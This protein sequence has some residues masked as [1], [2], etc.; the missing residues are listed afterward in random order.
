MSCGNRGPDRVDD[1]SAAMRRG[2]LAGVAGES[3]R[4]QGFRAVGV[5][6][7]KL[8]APVVAKRGGGVLV[9]LKADWAAV[10]GADW[11]RTAWPMS[12][13]RDGA[14]KLCTRPAA[15]LELQHRAPL[16]IER[17][18][19]YIGR[20][21]VTRLVLVQGGAPPR[22]LEPVR[23]A[24]RFPEAREAEALDRLLADIADAELRAALARLGRA[25]IGAGG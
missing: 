18:N 7:S 10:V 22:A 15:A 1:M 9:R 13:A 11:G 2:S 14:L 25:V 3:E 24:A 19:L 12:L 4:R 5:M 16:L 17:V 6:A 23:P 20:R 8:A 21:A